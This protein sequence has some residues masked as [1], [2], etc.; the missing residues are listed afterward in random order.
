MRLVFNH[1]LVSR[2]TDPCYFDL[3]VFCNPAWGSLRRGE[4]PHHR[5]TQCLRS[6]CV[7]TPASSSAPLLVAPKVILAV[8]VHW[9]E[10]LRRNAHGGIISIAP[11]DACQYLV[12]VRRGCVTR[13]SDQSLVCKVT[14]SHAAP[15]TLGLCQSGH[16]PRKARV[17]ARLTGVRGGWR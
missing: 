13:H 6:H 2:L 5:L 11:A 10:A 12:N 14:N 8:P 3:R 15:E 9:Q 16:F 17:A 7:G 4:L 1:W